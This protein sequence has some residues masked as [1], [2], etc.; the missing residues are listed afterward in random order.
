MFW[1]QTTGVERFPVQVTDTI[2][3]ACDR[4]RLFTRMAGPVTTGDVHLY[5]V[6]LQKDPH[7]GA[8]FDALIDVREMTDAP[9]QNDLREIVSEVSAV[10]TANAWTG[11]RALVAGRG[12]GY[13]ALCMFEVLARRL[14]VRYRLFADL[15][16]ATEWLNAGTAV[17]LDPRAP[18]N[19]RIRLMTAP[20]GV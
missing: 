14:P 9:P 16:E 11:R 5:L 13:R 2:S 7:Y 8:H 20:L 17:R 10:A 4:G 6:T 18:G 15:T 1:L 12:N 3:Y 19:D